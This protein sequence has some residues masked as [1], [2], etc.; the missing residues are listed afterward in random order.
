MTKHFLFLMKVFELRRLSREFYEAY[1]ASSFPEIERKANRPYVVLLVEI[2]QLRFAIPLRTNIRH[3]QCY[4]FRKSDRKTD[5]STGIDYSKA[6]VIEKESYL[7]EKASI[8]DSEY[9]ELSKKAFFIV[10]QFKRYF[11]GFVD[12][13]NNGGDERV[14]NRYRFSTLKYFDH[15]F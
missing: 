4:R 2:D 3:R 14:S 9:L 12:Y 10:K 1:P 7:G 13:K 8:N 5:S 11:E 15:L 6:V